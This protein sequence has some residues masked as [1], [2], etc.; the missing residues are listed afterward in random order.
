MILAV[1]DSGLITTIDQTNL[2]VRDL[3]LKW[4]QTGIRLNETLV[5]IALHVQQASCPPSWFC[6]LVSYGIPV[7][8]HLQCSESLECMVGGNHVQMETIID[9]LMQRY[10]QN[11][12]KLWNGLVHD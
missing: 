2:S 6:Q 4:I 10:R 1:Q 5:Q 3:K 7:Q 8:S 9:A 12:K 11:S